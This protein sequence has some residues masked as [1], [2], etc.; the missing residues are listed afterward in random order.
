MQIILGTK[1]EINDKLR[2]NYK[3]RNTEEAQKLAHQTWRG[4]VSG[5]MQDIQGIF[6]VS[7][8]Q[9]NRRKYG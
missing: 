5:I 8:F 6:R 3:G 4:N 7:Q 2:R 1:N 9:K